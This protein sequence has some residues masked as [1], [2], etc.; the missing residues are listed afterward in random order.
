MSAVQ[1]RPNVLI[2]LAD[3]MGFSDIASYGGEIPTPNLDRLAASGA[4]LTQFYNTA[5]C[6][7]S[8][9][10]LLTGLHP[11]Q[12]GI[13]ELTQDDG[14]GGYPGG[15]TE[16][17]ATLA[18]AFGD[19]GYRTFMVGKW[20]LTTDLEVD[21][22]IEAARHS[23]PTRRGFDRFWGTLS[24]CCS[25][26]SPTTLHD[27]EDPLDG[28]TLGE[29]FYY[30]DA[31]GER[32]ANAIQETPP[33]RAFFGYV[34]F[35]APHFP[36]HALDEDL[37]QVGG[38]FDAGWDELR[39][40]RRARQ[41]SMGIV[42][43]SATADAPDP[44]VI[45][46]ELE[47]EK[48]WQLSR[49]E[50]YGAQVYS[51]DRA[52]GTILDALARTGRDQNT[53]VIFLSDNGGSAED[54]T[55]EP[56][57]AWEARSRLL[58]HPAAAPDGT[59]LRIG[60]SPDI[61]P[62][63]ANA[64]TS[65]GRAW[66][67]VSNTPF[68]F[69]KRWVHEGGIA[70]PLIVSWPAGGVVAGSIVVAP[71]QLTDVAPTLFEAVGVHP[72]IARA[73]EPLPPLLGHSFLDA[74][75]GRA[76]EPHDLFWEHIGNGAIR[77]GRWKLVREHGGEWELYDID[78]DRSETTDLAGTEPARVAEMAARWENWAELVGALPR[79]AVLAAR[80]LTE[81]SMAQYGQIDLTTRE[82]LP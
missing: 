30:T 68:R 69:Y 47:P 41:T 37:R 73:G 56:A 62:G 67:H 32:A 57:N 9:A 8:R 51:M 25:Y 15:L 35:T 16:R 17:C 29:G 78:Q 38:L 61:R 74:L 53:L 36:L 72:L 70:T 59:P 24:G 64:W 21:D 40:A 54:V 77:D 48:Q 23:W 45:P 50:A 4:R 46:W 5:R 26:F 34:A 58:T 1:Q 80:Q 12:T 49:M 7:P 75:R 65:Y 71:H 81:D 18:E 33:D 43:E 14:P 31:I 11:H 3:D 19:A 20:H 66:A 2:L 10:S 27:G 42:D 82:R 60:N 22:N 13:G 52:I 63:A 79:A 6:S 28:A 76:A 55:S 44:E 39:A